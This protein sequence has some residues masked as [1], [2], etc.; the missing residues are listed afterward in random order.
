MP[1]A[2]PLMFFNTPIAAALSLS[3]GIFLNPAGNSG[4]GAYRLH[5]TP[6][7]LV[8]RVQAVNQCASY[9]LMPLYPLLAGLALHTLGGPTTIALFIG[10]T[11]AVALIPTL[12]HPVRSV[13]RPASWPPPATSSRL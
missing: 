7:E 2:I 12:S 6:P 4:I 8:G 13:P 11:A 3:V 9:S 1:L 10:L 5:I